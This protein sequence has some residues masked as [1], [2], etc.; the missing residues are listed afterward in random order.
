M[1][2]EFMSPGSVAFTPPLKAKFCLSIVQ[3]NQGRKKRNC[4]LILDLQ[5]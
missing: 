4:Q 5:T 2:E 1:Y 3:A